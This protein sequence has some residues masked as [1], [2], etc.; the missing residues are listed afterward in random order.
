MILAGAALIMT[1]YIAVRE[2]G[3]TFASTE[4]VIIGAVVMAL[5]GPS[6]AYL[7]AHR[8]SQRALKFWVVPSLCVQLLLPTG[9]RFAV[10]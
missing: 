3:S 7:L 5:I 10:G 9:F 8:L 1:Q 6:I 4:L 2:I